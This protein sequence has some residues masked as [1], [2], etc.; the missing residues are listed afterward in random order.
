M[1]EDPKLN[2]MVDVSTFWNLGNSIVI[3]TYR[4]EHQ[5]TNAST[6]RE[7]WHCFDGIILHKAFQFNGQRTFFGVLHPT[8]EHWE[9]FEHH[10]SQGHLHWNS[11]MIGWLVM[12]IWIIF[13]L[14]DSSTWYDMS[15]PTSHERHWQLSPLQRRSR[16]TSGPGGNGWTVLEITVITYCKLWSTSCRSR[17]PTLISEKMNLH[18]VN[19]ALDDTLSGNQSCSID[20]GTTAAI[21]SHIWIL[22][23]LYQDHCCTMSY[24][25]LMVIM[26]IT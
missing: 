13:R 25:W 10:W 4:G 24:L 5:S 22:G 23:R 20:F 2:T 8:R 19:I 3:E 1:F 12:E 6:T 16:S 11:P 18:V 21:K 14:M 7:I 15:V 26:I 9:L 17:D